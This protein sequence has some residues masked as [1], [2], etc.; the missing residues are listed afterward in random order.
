ITPW[1]NEYRVLFARPGEMTDKLN[2]RVH[3]I[4]S[5]GYT[6]TIDNHGQQQWTVVT[7]LRE[8][9]PI[10]SP[11]QV[12]IA[13]EAS[14]ENIARLKEWVKSFAPDIL[15][16]VPEEEF[17]KFFSRRTYRGAVVE[18]SHL[19]MHD[20]IA[21][22]G[23]SAHSVL[24]PTGEG[25]NSGLEDTLVFGTCIEENPNAPFPLYEEKRKP[26][27]DALLEYAIYLNTLV[28][29]GAERVARGIFI[30]LEA[31]TSESIGKQLF[32]PLG[33]NRGP[34]RDI[35][36]SWKTKRA[37][38]LNAARV[39]SYPIGFVISAIMFIPDLFK[40]KNVHSKPRDTTL[41]SI[42]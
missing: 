4:F 25:I 36:A 18:C 29:C 2:P 35:I 20:W 39:F 7:C 16:L 3:Y 13:D 26:D 14:E 11:S 12:V 19:Q 8:S 5:G 31:Q 28:N 38:M 32:G 34:Y 10:S 9:D 27:I 30:V 21:L 37:F 41:K 42:V 22:L 17:T 23:D 33:V 1:T 6:A 24:P 40:S 15:P